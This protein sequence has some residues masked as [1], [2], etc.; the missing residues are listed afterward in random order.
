MYI[1]IYCIHM[2]K[3]TSSGFLGEFQKEQEK[4]EK[5]QRHNQGI[6]NYITIYS[7]VLMLI[8]TQVFLP[9]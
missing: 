2:Y 1:S 5:R 9:G 7:H 8:Q 3:Q 4:F 6:Y